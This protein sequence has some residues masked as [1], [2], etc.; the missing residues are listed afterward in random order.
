MGLNNHIQ[1]FTKMMVCLE[2]KRKGHLTKKGNDYYM[3]SNLLPVWY[4]CNDDGSFKLDAEG[5]KLLRYDIPQELSSLT[6]AEKLLIRRCAP[7]V[8]LVHIA[9]GVT[10]L[11]GHC[12]CYPQNITE[13]CKELPKRKEE[14]ITFVRKVGGR[15]TKGLTSHIDAFKVRKSKVLAALHWLK[16]HNIHYH[17]IIITTS[18]LNWMNNE[19][20][21]S[22][23]VTVEEHC[24][25]EDIDN[26]EVVVQSGTVS[27]VQTET[28]RDKNDEIE[29]CGVNASSTPF[30]LSFF[31]EQCIN[32]IR[33]TVIDN[34]SGEGLM[35]FP[36]T[37]S[38]DP[39]T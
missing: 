37:D 31:Q 27:H 18:N 16:L 33:K 4:E 12:V 28:M 32:K 11:K 20:E 15:D 36:P 19:E 6:M 25:D 22:I 26:R 24:F 17:D 34:A 2:C 7:F 39:I 30:T 35:N 8:P 23:P 14:V 29:Y 3:D 1:E 9:T 10:G 38:Y 21:A 13:L 5:K